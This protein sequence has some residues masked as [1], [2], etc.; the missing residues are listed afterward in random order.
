MTIIPFGFAARGDGLRM[1]TGKTVL[2]Q[3]VK[4]YKV[5]RHYTCGNDDDALAKRKEMRKDTSK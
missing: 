2:A 1:R 4:L 5:R 3:A